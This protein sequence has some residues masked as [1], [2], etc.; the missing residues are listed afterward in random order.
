MSDS[1]SL[2]TDAAAQAVTAWRDYG[3]Q[4]E[5]HGQRHHMTLAELRAT[6]GD[7]YARYV[8]AKA[9]ELQAREAAYQRVAAHVRGHA[10]RLNNTITTFTGT[11]DESRARINSVLGA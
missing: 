3:D 4:V 8:E 2:D 5:S 7:T 11:D 10:D 6:V 9:A 1:I